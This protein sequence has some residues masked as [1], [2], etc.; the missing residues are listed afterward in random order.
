MDSMDIF[1]FLLKKK[2]KKKYILLEPLKSAFYPYYP[3]YLL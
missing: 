1:L 3:Y 2:K